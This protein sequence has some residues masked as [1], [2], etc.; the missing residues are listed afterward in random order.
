MEDTGSTEENTDLPAGPGSAFTRLL[1]KIVDLADLEATWWHIATELL[2]FIAH[3]MPSAASWDALEP[4][5]PD[6]TV[7][8][9]SGAVREALAKLAWIP[10]AEGKLSY[11]TKQERETLRSVALRQLA[12]APF[13][14]SMNEAAT[15]LGTAEAIDGLAGHTFMPW[16]KADG[17]LKVGPGTVYPIRQHDPATW[18]GPKEENPA[19]TRAH[20]RP[21]RQLL[22]TEC[23]QV[24][25]KDISSYSFVLDFGCWDNLSDL[26]A[27]RELIAAVGQPNLDLDEFDID[28]GTKDP[29]TY[30]NY[31]P[32][33]HEV[34]ARLVGQL[35]DTSGAHNAEILVLPEYGLASKSKESLVKKLSSIDRVPR[36][37]ICG[38]SSGTDRDG[39]VINDAVM[40]ISDAAGKVLRIVDL[41]RKLH[42]AKVSGYI[43][44]IKRRS[45]IRLFLAQQWTIATLICVDSMDSD[46]IPHLADFGV[47]LLLIPA[48]SAK[49]AAMISAAISLSSLSQAFVVIATGPA[50]WESTRLPKEPAPE[51]RSEAVFTG[52]YAIEPTAVTASSS[53]YLLG[54]RTN[55]WTFS[56]KTRALADYVV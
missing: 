40:I 16:Y 42:P 14:Q 44:R 55:L 7:A 18:L 39:Y 56:Y 13:D 6:S 51:L 11:T 22:R 15:A 21:T 23:L 50:R 30:A 32:A 38:V 3:N 41:P 26:G 54:S 43:E 36:L 5:E 48:L 46:I 34:Q 1:D 49:S 37:V 31:G 35:I 29:L 45:E 8:A 25:P 2:R 53:S 10:P 12:E 52:P 28:L 33:D 17:E 27:S 20:N 19:N 4:F 24:A 9:T 47:N